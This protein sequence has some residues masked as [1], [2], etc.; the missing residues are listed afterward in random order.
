MVNLRC[1][2]SY[3]VGNKQVLGRVN[4]NRRGVNNKI[5]KGA[6]RNRPRLKQHN[7]KN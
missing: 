2:G 4:R 1:K 3:N 6:E 5:I 7:Y